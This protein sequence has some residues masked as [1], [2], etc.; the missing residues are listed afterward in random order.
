MQNGCEVGGRNL[1]RGQG[2]RG[3]GVGT[4]MQRTNRRFVDVGA[5]ERGNVKAVVNAGRQGRGPG[6]YG[7]RREG[8]RLERGCKGGRV[9]ANKKDTVGSHQVAKMR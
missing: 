3:K 7:S 2:A 6:Q 8:K 9:I 1:R 4:V 5:G